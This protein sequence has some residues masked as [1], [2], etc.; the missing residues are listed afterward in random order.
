MKD[1]CLTLRPARPAD[2]PA[3]EA[4]LRG[5]GLP[6]DGIPS[7]LD[8]FLVATVDDS[9]EPIGVGGLERY[10]SS[11]LL[12]STAVNPAWRSSGVGR[13]LV[14]ALLEE[15]DR[16]GV[17]D[18]FLLTTTAEAYFPR[19]G[20]ACVTREVVPEAVQESAEF[21]GAC[22]DSAVV[23]HRCCEPSA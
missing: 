6:L 13:A 2:R 8:G 23:M 16:S 1:P 21:R 11:A 14:N 9:D 18:V 17:R 19:F 3:V 12:R 15:T 22:P 20:F 4:L 10:G 5:A 7:G